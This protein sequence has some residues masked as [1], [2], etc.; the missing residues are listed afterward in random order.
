MLGS[1]VPRNPFVAGLANDKGE[2]MIVA[3]GYLNLGS[4]TPHPLP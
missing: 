1:E 4:S 3:A 2:R